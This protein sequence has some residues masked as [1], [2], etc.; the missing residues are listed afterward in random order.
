[1]SD[2][3]QALRLESEPESLPRLDTAQEL[4]S[5]LTR[6]HLVALLQPRSSGGAQSHPV[7]RLLGVCDELRRSLPLTEPVAPTLLP[8]L[9]RLLAA[10]QA[11]GYF[12][13]GRLTTRRL[14]QR[15]GQVT[16]AGVATITLA[17][18]N[19]PDDGEM[20]F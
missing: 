2:T 6:A 20:V 4:L 13:F 17:H 8:R 18:P 10:A 11:E 9:S 1:M 19:H 15:A 16:I 7:V 14:P 12:L 3:P 5:L